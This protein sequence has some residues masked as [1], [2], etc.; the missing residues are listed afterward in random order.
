MSIGSNGQQYQ[1]DVNPPISFGD[2]VHWIHLNG[3]N[4]HHWIQWTCP[5]DSPMV[6]IGSNGHHDVH[7]T[8]SLNDMM[9]IGQSNGVHWIQWIQWTRL[10]TLKTVLPNLLW[11]SRTVRNILLHTLEHVVASYCDLK[12]F[13]VFENIPFLT[14]HNNYKYKPLQ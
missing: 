10:A 4:G 6:S 5:L 11:C 8:S 14:V 3:S 13:L 2:V 7:W 9:S 1:N 12:H